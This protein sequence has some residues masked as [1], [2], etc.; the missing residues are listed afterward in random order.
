MSAIAR[1]EKPPTT[2]TPLDV[3]KKRR[4][5]GYFCLRGRARFEAD[6]DFTTRLRLDALPRFF[7]AIR[8]LGDRF[9]DAFCLVEEGAPLVRTGLFTVRL[10]VDDPD[11]LRFTPSDERSIPRS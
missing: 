8:A 2:R 4:G 1:R 10:A 3:A 9:W 11:C 5:C 6:R 7:F